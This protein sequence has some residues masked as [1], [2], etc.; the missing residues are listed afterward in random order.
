MGILCDFQFLNGMD[1]F[2]L[3]LLELLSCSVKLF[4][5]HL[6]LISM[7]FL[8]FFPEVSETGV[9]NLLDF[10]FAFALSDLFCLIHG[11]LLGR[12]A[13]IISFC[14]SIMLRFFHFERLLE[15]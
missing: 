10:T 5:V 1:F 14:K 4:N 6:G 12:L 15:N 8:N 2:F 7:V 9:F 3:E 11:F 13:H